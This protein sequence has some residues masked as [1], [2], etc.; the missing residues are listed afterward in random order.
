LEPIYNRG[1]ND[2]LT[3]G[4]NI[5]NGGTGEDTLY[6]GSGRD[7]FVLASESGIDTIFNFT[8]GS[9]YLG[10]LNGLTFEQITITQGIGTNTSDTLISKQDGEVLATLIGVEANTLGLWDF[11]NLG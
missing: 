6:G 2:Y 9:D 1:G 4:D 5:L 7:M 11:A 8:V 10:L 3:G